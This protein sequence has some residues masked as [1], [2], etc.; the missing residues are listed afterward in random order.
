LSIVQSSVVD[1]NAST[2]EDKLQHHQEKVALLL[3]SAAQNSKQNFLKGQCQDA[4]EEEVEAEAPL[5]VLD[6]CC[7]DLLKKLD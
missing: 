6:Y 1:L 5:R 2:R 3:I 7:N 4:E